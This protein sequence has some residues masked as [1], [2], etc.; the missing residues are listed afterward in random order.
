MVWKNLDAG[1]LHE[2]VRKPFEEKT[3]GKIV[4]GYG[5]TETSPVLSGG[6]FYGEHRCVES[7]GIP[8]PGTDWKIFPSE[9]FDAGPIEGIGEENTGE[10]CAA[11][12][13][14][15]KEYLDRPE[16]TAATI[17]EWGG[18]KWLLTGDIGFLDEYGRG[19][20][21][22]RKK[23]LIKMRGYSIYPKEVESLVGMHPEVSEVAVA[24]LPDIETGESVKAWCKLVE[25]SSLSAEELKAWCKE[26]MTHYKVPK[27]YEF[28]PEIPKNVLGKVQRRLL[29]EN[30]PLFKRE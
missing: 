19:F 7:I 6:N 3:R 16:E 25:G 5:L 24:G 17:K 18:K 4:E 28:I 23:Q 22:D 27:H 30:D 8:F 13:Q 9:D 26:N 10:I 11:G 12:P 2:Y 1:P 14:I 20:I 29:Q 21:R 15:M